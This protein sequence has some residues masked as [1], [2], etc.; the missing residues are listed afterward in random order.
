MGGSE[1]ASCLLLGRRERND[2]GRNAPIGVFF[3]MYGLSSVKATPSIIGR[4]LSIL[5]QLL[6]FRRASK[7]CLYLDCLIYQLFDFIAYFYAEI[8]IYPDCHF[9]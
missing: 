4:G 2:L 9:V 5:G 6:V 3:W 7:N 1:D 8:R